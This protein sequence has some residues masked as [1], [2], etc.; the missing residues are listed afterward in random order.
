MCKKIMAAMLPLCILCL[1][2]GCGADVG[3]PTGQEQRYSAD[4]EHGKGAQGYVQPE[5]KGEITIASF[6]EQ[7]FLTT[8]AAQFMELYPEVT[9]SINVYDEASGAGSVE[10]YQTYLNTKIMTKKA[11]DIMFN[12]FLPVEKYSEM[13]VFADLSDYMKATPEFNDENYFMNV[14][15]AAREKNG[16]LYLLPYM[17]KF[18]ALGFT[19]ELF[20]KQAVDRLPGA[21]FTECMELAKDLLRDTDKMNAYLVH[22]NEMSYANYMI[23]DVF[24]ELIDME[25]KEVNIHSDTYTNIIKEA[26]ELSK[27]NAFG[28]GIDYY[29]SEYYYAAVCDYDVQAAFYELD[30][31]AGISHSRPLADKE[32]NVAINANACLALNSASENQDLAWEFIKYLLSDEVQSLPSVHGLAVNKRGFEAAVTRYYKFYADGGNG[33]VEKEAYEELLE[34]WMEQINACDTVDA[35]LWALIEEENSKFFEGVQTA[36]ETAS[37]LQRKIEQYLHE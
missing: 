25:N 30:T 3:N 22:K 7:E 34:S 1:L 23:R 5:M 35:A 29:H 4:G 20:T 13:G 17:A 8:A 19:D 11:E 2:S 6:Y 21:R 12:S 18:E 32:G 37:V 36:E 27:G 9:V 33:A 15:Q 14:L 16:E 24:S 31:Q 10:A 28:R 26:K